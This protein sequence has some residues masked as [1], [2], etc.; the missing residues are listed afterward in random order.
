MKTRHNP[1]RAFRGR[2]YRKGAAPSDPREAGYAPQSVTI[3]DCR[4]KSAKEAD[5]RERES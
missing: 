1:E 2:S 5:R 4:E 3:R